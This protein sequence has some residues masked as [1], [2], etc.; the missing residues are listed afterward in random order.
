MTDASG[1]TSWTYDARDRVRTKATPQGTLTYTW[2]LNGLAAS[3]VSSNANGVSVAYGYDSLN[4][5]D[6]VTDNRG[7]G[8]RYVE[9]SLIHDLKTERSASY[10]RAGK[11]ERVTRRRTRG[12]LVV[13]AFCGYP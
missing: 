2:H 12:P 4:R 6:S 8:T 1:T 7:G 13:P 10:V 5:L 3:V 11:A 9:Q